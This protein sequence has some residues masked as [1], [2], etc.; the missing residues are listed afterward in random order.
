MALKCWEQIAWRAAAAR[1]LWT[2]E[3]VG[4]TVLDSPGWLHFSVGWWRLIATAV[5]GVGVAMRIL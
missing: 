5:A 2:W 1:S 3:D 4:R